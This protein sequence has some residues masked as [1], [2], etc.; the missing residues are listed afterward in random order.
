[1]PLVFKTLTVKFTHLIVALLLLG[2]HAGP[3]ARQVFHDLA[4]RPTR[5]QSF[6]DPP[7]L[8]AEKD[9]R[10]E[11]ALWWLH[12]LVHFGLRCIHYRLVKRIYFGCEA[13]LLF[14]YGLLYLLCRIFWEVL[15][16]LCDFV[17][18]RGRNQ[19]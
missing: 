6:H 11:W 8:L 19:K 15:N 16:L 2:G 14:D 5:V 10:T 4:S 7:L 18:I 1:M 9:V 12:Q 17:L 3:G 13:F